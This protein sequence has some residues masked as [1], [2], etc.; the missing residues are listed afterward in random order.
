MDSEL[1]VVDSIVEPAC[2]NKA[3]IE[4]LE[5]ITADEQLHRTLALSVDTSVTTTLGQ[6]TKDSDVRF[7]SGA[8]VPSEL[9]MIVHPAQPKFD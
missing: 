3:S 2:S 7:V 6:V 1:G 4:N 9:A 5:T 8:S